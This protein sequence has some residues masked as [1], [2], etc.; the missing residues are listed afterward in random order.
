[1]L[2]TIKQKVLLGLLTLFLVLFLFL[3]LVIHYEMRQTLLPINTELT[4]QV[5]DK[6]S[7]EI[8]DWFSER[9]SEVATLADYAYRRDLETQ[10]FFIE[11]KAL[12]QRRHDIYES[13]RL[14]DTDG[15]SHSWITPPFSIAERPYYQKITQEPTL[16]YSISNAL[17]SK[18]AKQDIIIILYELD[19]PTTDKIQYIA[20]AVSVNQMKRMTQELDMYDGVGTLVNEHKKTDLP[21]FRWVPNKT[22]RFT[23]DIPLLP[24]WQITYEVSQASLL[25]TSLHIQKLLYWVLS[26]LMFAIFFFFLFQLDILIK[27]IEALTQTMTRV[28]NG[29][30]NLRVPVTSD[31]EIGLL[32]QQFNT[33]LDSLALAE[34]EKAK[35]QVRLLQEQV[36]PHFLYNTLNTIQ[37]L[38]ASGDM[39]KVEQMIQSLSN[40]FRR[41]LNDGNDWSSLEN[42]LSHVESYLAIQAIRYDRGIVLNTQVPEEVLSCP[43]PHFI[44]QPIVEN[45][46]YYGIRPTEEEQHTITITACQNE[47]HITLHI[48]NTGQLPSIDTVTAI[49]AFLEG[50]AAKRDAVGFGLFSIYSQ[51]SYTYGEQASVKMSLQQQMCRFTL[52]IPNFMKGTENQDEI[53]HY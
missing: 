2:K 31:D 48:D 32:S 33:M 41:G 27:P 42:E 14:V 22:L 15:M 52:T 44:L 8:D 23:G 11:T 53:T 12:E 3:Y 1:M 28:A 13:I 51:L 47:Q 43:V 29:E 26:I 36:K 45:A 25:R 4:Q 5:V 16:K 20:A 7:K 38:A 18:E 40:Y 10:D 50:D 39:E 24:E 37:W 34:K 9:I 35:H 46:L 19:Q 30:K 49:N 6:K 17:H 21:S